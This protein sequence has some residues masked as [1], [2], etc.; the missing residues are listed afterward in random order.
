MS[1]VLSL[2]LA[3]PAHHPANGIV[4]KQYYPGT[5]I[6]LPA[7]VV[8]NYTPEERVRNNLRCYCETV[9]STERDCI[10]AGFS[11]RECVAKTHRWASANLV[12]KA[13]VAQGV[14]PIP[15]RNVIVNIQGGR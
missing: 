13:S 8:Y 1:F 12:D 6:A 7:G 11:K 14:T 15:R 10:R 5:N 3:M 9:K 2:M 4:C